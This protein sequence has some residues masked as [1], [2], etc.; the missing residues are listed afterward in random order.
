MAAFGNLSRLLERLKWRREEGIISA[1]GWRV[2]DRL[3]AGRYGAPTLALARGGLGPV[4]KRA[5]FPSS[6]GVTIVAPVPWP[7]R[8]NVSYES[9]NYCRSTVLWT[10][11]ES[12]G[13]GVPWR[14]VFGPILPID[15]RYRV[16]HLQI[17]PN[18]SRFGLVVSIYGFRVIGSITLPD[19]TS[20]ADA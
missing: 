9:G 7:P 15:N 11:A 19:P 6:Q 17:E 10:G 12:Q 2:R 5:E 1:L 3:R 8:A 4:A 16:S 18:L 13:T 14:A 20:R